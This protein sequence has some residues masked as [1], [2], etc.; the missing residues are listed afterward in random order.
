MKL[1]LI[2]SYSLSVFRVLMPIRSRNAIARA[3]SLWIGFQARTSQP[4]NSNLPS[5]PPKVMITFL[6]WSRSFG[7]V[8]GRIS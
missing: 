6:R 2:L 1:A 5:A 4:S 8:P 7:Q 3:L